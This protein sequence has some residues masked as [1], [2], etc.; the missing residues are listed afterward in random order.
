[1]PIYDSLEVESV[2]DGGDVGLGGGYDGVVECF[3]EDW[4]GRLL[5]LGSGVVSRVPILL[6][7]LGL[8]DLWSTRL[9]R[10]WH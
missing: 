1:M 7:L 6:D 4:E 9:T 2:E 3:E 10:H 8:L 5:P